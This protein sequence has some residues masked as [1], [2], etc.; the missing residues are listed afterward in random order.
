MKRLITQAA[1]GSF[2]IWMN[3]SEEIRRMEHV[4]DIVD[5]TENEAEAN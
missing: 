5:D 3:V 2:K 1:R 4:H